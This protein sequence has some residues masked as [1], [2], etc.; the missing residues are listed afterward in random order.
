MYENSM[1][2]TTSQPYKDYTPS[3]LTTSDSWTST[4]T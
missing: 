4:K 3:Y 2:S 1:W